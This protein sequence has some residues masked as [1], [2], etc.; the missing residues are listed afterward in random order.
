MEFDVNYIVEREEILG[1]KK[2][3]TTAVVA[4]P[5]SISN[6]ILWIFFFF[7]TSTTAD[8]KRDR[9][10]PHSGSARTDFNSCFIVISVIVNFVFC[11]YIVDNRPI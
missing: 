5:T 9:N 1:S 11:V 7:V 10:P 8:K 4:G 6:V 2:N 3:V